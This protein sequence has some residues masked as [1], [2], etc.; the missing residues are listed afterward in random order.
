MRMYKVVTPATT[1]T[2]PAI[3]P[4]GTAS[5]CGGSTSGGSVANVTLDAA[6]IGGAAVLSTSL[7]LGVDGKR[8]E[9]AEAHAASSSP[10]LS[11]GASAELED[12]LHELS[13]AVV[14]VTGAAE[15]ARSRMRTPGLSV[16]LFVVAAAFRPHLFEQV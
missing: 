8:Y 14:H 15:F 1:T 16:N 5:A 4:G 9:T 6:V 13:A 7:L 12:A 10:A 3:V 11:F 2:A